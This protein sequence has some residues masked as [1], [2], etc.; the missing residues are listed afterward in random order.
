MSLVLPLGLL[1]EA[2]KIINGEY[3]NLLIVKEEDGGPIDII[4]QHAGISHHHDSEAHGGA[5]WWGKEAKNDVEFKLQTTE[6]EIVELL[7]PEERGEMEL[8]D[9]LD[10]LFQA[11]Y[12]DRMVDQL[13]IRKVDREAERLK[14]LKYKEE[15]MRVQKEKDKKVEIEAAKRHAEFEKRKADQLKVKEEA[16]R[17]L[18]ERVKYA[19]ALLKAETMRLA[20]IKHAREIEERKRHI[21]GQNND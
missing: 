1:Y 8:E 6:E 9:I 4:V 10:T 14:L 3:H 18:Q 15:A 16:R 7:D 2:Q 21:P 11:I 20:A 17:Y 5:H 19:R 13:K 12:F